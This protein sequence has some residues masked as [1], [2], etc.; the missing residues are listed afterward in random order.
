MK[1]VLSTEVRPSSVADADD[2]F[3][4]G[5]RYVRR[6][7][8]DGTVVIA[9]IPLTLEDLLYPE[10]GDFVVHEPW[11]TQD[12]TYCYSTLTAWY[13]DQP[14]VV[15]LGDCRVDWGVAGIRPLGPDIVVLFAVRHWLQ[16]TTFHLAE[17]GGQPV[18]VMEIASPSTR[19]HDLETKR[20]FYYRAGVQTYVIVDR[21]PEGEAP[22][23]LIG[24][25][26]GPMDWVPLPPDARGHVPLG[27]VGLALG[28][29]EGRPW[30]YNTVT[31]EREPDRPELQQALAA[32]R[33]SMQATEAR[34]QDAEARAQ[35]AESR[36]QDA[37]QER[38]Q[39]EARVRAL[40]EQLRQRPG[41]AG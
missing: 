13:A 38:R 22:P 37:V 20:A 16:Q 3:R 19:R 1:H 18:L 10:E 25:Q 31:G 2:P 32:A 36:L 7:E 23:R 11:H 15:V 35:N 28:V 39:L 5:W 24:F 4:Y 40:E 21:G 41:D 29:E 30:L 27:P 9:E 8:P 17:E 6:T 12:F 33:A 34:A 26:R 14:E